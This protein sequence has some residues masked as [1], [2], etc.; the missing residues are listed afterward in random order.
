MDLMGVPDLAGARW[1]LLSQGER[2]RTL[3]AR[4]L[5]G[6]PRVL[7]LDEPTAGLD[8]AGREQLLASLS[9]LRARQPDVATLLVTHHVEELPASTS[10]AILLRDGRMLAAGRAD[11]VLTS[12]LV[13]DCF[14]YPVSISRNASRWACLAVTSYTT[15]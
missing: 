6:Q 2:R 12:D 13:S 7:L 9:A 10:H 5:M 14:G 11:Q 8:L 3:I 1:Q 4:A 15:S